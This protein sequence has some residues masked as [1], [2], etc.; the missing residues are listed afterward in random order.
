MK[1]GA[2]DNMNE[3]KFNNDQLIDRIASRVVK[4]IGENAPVK[5]IRR[6]QILTA[7]LGAVG[8]ALFINGVDKLVEGLSLWLLIILGL[9]MM[10]ITGLL[11]SNLNR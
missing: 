5:Q 4:L 11:L 3:E 10:A 1:S 9:V 7:L 6:S 2:R 8:F